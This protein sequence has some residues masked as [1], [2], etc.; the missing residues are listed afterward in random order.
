MQI[1]KY[2]ANGI[3]LTIQVTCAN[4][5]VACFSNGKYFKI[6]NYFHVKNMSGSHKPEACF[7]P[8]NI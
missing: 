1:E 8:E 3:V 2:I 4:W 5:L 7:S 6:F